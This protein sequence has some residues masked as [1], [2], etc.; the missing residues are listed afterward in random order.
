LQGLRLPFAVSVQFLKGRINTQR[1]GMEIGS[2]QWAFA[3]STIFLRFR[4]SFRPIRDASGRRF[5]PIRP[6]SSARFEPFPN[7]RDFFALPPRKID[8]LPVYELVPVP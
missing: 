8:R 6:I 3:D 7:A 5:S 4:S 2:A 1:V